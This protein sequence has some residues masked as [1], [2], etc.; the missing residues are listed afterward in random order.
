[1][2]NIVCFLLCI[3]VHAAYG[4]KI[5]KGIVLDAKTNLPIENITV[6]PAP[7]GTPVHTDG[8]GRFMF[9]S[10]EPLTSVAFIS[11]GYETKVLPITEMQ[12]NKAIYLQ[13]QKIQ[14]ENVVVTAKA[15]KEYSIISKTDIKMRGINNAQEILRM[16][17]GLF[18]GQH[19]GGGKAEQIF[20]RGFDCDHGTD[21]NITADGLPVNM[22]SHAHGQ[23]YAD[24]HFIIPETIEQV[25]FQK[26][27]YTTSK[28]NFTTSG[29][30]DVQTKNALTGNLVKLEGGMYDT[31]RALGMFNLLSTTAKAK[32]Q[33]WYVASEYAYS[34][35]YF[36]HPQ[37]FKRT[38]FFSKYNGKITGQ[39]YLTIS[40]SSFSSKWNASGQ[41][42][43]RA[44]NSG[45]IS[46]YGAID[47]TEGGQT[48]RSN[49]NAQ[50]ITTLKNGSLIKN[51][52]YYSNYY[53]D[54]HSNFTFYL[55]DSVNGDQLRQ[56]EARN[57][58]GYNGV[59]QHQSNIGSVLFNTEMGAGV[60]Y[61][62]I[63]NI[64]L[65]HTKDRY[66]L[67]DKMAYGNIAETNLSAYIS[68]AIHLSEKL[69][70]NAGLR[71]DMFLNNYTDHLKAD[72]LFKA[73]AAILSPKL[74]IAYQYNKTTQFY[75]NIGKGFHS[76]DTR[77]CVMEKGKQVLPP[78]YAADLGTVL[79]PVKN[80]L[81]QFAV[82]YLWLDQEF[83]YNGDDGTPSPS[84]K[85]QRKGADFSIRYEPLHSLY[86]DADVNY[87]H[88]RFI[89][90][91][92]GQDYIPLAPVW[93]STG[94]ITYKNK[95]GF[96]GSLRYRW[97]GNRPANEDYSLTAQGYFVNDFV[98]NYTGKKYEVGLT[99]N[100]VFNVKWK[101]T[102]FDTI[103]RLKNEVAPV[104]EINFTAG[105]KLAAKLSFSVY[106]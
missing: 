51:Q 82:W 53:F 72:S 50:F 31:Y 47:S 60:R 17:P 12:D 65:S 19:Q 105:T 68:E 69:N 95:N 8:R 20:M 36:D 76:N 6:Q 78:A 58:L 63:N 24:M 28:G 62:R 104:E 2:R 86:I 88:G 103:S 102:Q 59:Y 29:Y 45:L 55:N 9:K 97:L 96:N 94:G 93:S 3:S 100:N 46:F 106:F 35:G 73:N 75:I 26:G 92:K 54:L 38:N 56:K 89:E 66:T 101:E 57:I 25:D 71:A 37:D 39:T 90:E 40:A 70:V 79:K 18:I 21:I 10:I 49:I 42:P 84:G 1:M 81:M 5:I 98:L 30:V 23:G 52:F 34:N 43:E 4:Q 33:S 22:V 67:L 83:V 13:Q 64:E 74:G 27:P 15:G 48:S 14:L 32:Q 77:V 61:D 11:I 80:L 16:V 91:L 7:A 99:I 44:V 85:T 87:A 41:I